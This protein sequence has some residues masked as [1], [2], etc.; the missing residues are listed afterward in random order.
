MRRQA[1]HRKAELHNV[2]FNVIDT[3][4]SLRPLEKPDKLI[5]R[6]SIGGEIL[7]FCNTQCLV[8]AAGHIRHELKVD[9][10]ALVFVPT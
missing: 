5:D 2:V 10:W 1:P 8:G 6:L 7:S 9:I 3:G 4:I